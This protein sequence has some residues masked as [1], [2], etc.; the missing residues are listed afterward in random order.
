LASLT[1]YC[2][3]CAPSGR[4]DGSATGSSNGGIFRNV[5]S[6]FASAFRLLEAL[7]DIPLGLARTNP[8]Q[9]L[10]RIE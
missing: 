7:I 5:L 10:V 8:H 3:A 9:V 2:A 4:P 6:P 1:D